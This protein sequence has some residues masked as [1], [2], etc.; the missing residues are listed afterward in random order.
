MVPAEEKKILVYGPSSRV[1]MATIQL[2]K[3]PGEIVITT[4]Y[5]NSRHGF[6]KKLG[7]HYIIDRTRQDIADEVKKKLLQPALTL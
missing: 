4:I 3:V 5:G 1:G 6:V 2:A 7:A